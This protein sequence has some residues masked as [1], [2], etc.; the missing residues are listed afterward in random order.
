MV[1][2]VFVA[3]AC[4]ESGS[5]RFR[6]A[7]GRAVRARE[8]ARC[9]GAAGCEVRRSFSRRGVRTVRAVRGTLRRDTRGPVRN[10]ISRVL[11]L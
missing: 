7:M 10:I 6:D 8:R 3:R 2:I 1:A 4:G 9:R 5:A 11:D